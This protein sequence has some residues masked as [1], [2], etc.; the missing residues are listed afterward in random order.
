M[1]IEI[2]EPQSVKSLTSSAANDHKQQ[3]IEMDIGIGIYDILNNEDE[4]VQLINKNIENQLP[5]STE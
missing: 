4:D 2:L 3:Q 5:R 1:N